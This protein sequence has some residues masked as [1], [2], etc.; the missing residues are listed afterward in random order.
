MTDKTGKDNEFIILFLFQ[1]LEFTERYLLWLE[2]ETDYN[3]KF[4]IKK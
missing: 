1:L 3:I 4:I 2:L